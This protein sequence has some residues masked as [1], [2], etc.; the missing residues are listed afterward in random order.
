M[1]DLIN[2]L[3]RIESDIKYWIIFDDSVY[4]NKVNSL[5]QKRKLILNKIKEKNNVN[6]R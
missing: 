1:H 3:K 2:Q 6:V 4:Q 5:I